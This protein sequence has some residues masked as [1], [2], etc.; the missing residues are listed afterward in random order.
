MPRVGKDGRM[1]FDPDQLAGKV[2]INTV[3]PVNSGILNYINQFGLAAGRYKANDPDAE[4]YYEG[5][6]YVMNLGPTGSFMGFAKCGL[7]NNDDPAQCHR[8]GWIPHIW[9]QYCGESGVERSGREQLPEELRAVRR[10]Q[11]YAQERLYSG[12][13]LD[14]YRRPDLYHRVHGRGGKGINAG[15]LE[16]EI[17]RTEGGLRQ[18]DQSRQQR[19]RL[20]SG[21]F[22]VV[23]ETRTI[24]APIKTATSD[25]RPSSSTPRNTVPPRRWARTI[26]FGW[27]PS[28]VVSRSRTKTTTIRRTTTSSLFSTAL[29]ATPKPDVISEWNARGAVY[30]DGTKL[31]D[32]YTLASQP[33][34]LSRG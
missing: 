6:R 4:L 1:I 20:R 10:R 28:G 19:R 15:N 12:R 22:G 30:T 8:A 27:G 23:G 29:S 17:G 32:T 33:E 24:S 11:E 13:L 21:G 7:R 9:C 5:L 34:N 3:K 16:D 26:S 18:D 2:G 14:E 31:P 25:S